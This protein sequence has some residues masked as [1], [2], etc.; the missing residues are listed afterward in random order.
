MSIFV[1]GNSSVHLSGA[2]S[3]EPLA[4]VSAAAHLIRVP[5]LFLPS[6]AVDPLR[7]HGVRFCRAVHRLYRMVKL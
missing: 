5:F 2:A 4:A 1:F 6:F 3:A 7:G